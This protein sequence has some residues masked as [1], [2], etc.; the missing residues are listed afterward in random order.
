MPIVNMLD[1]KTD[2]SKLAAAVESDAGREVIIAR[3]DNQQRMPIGFFVAQAIAEPY[4]FE[5][6]ADRPLRPSAHPLGI[7]HVRFFALPSKGLTVPR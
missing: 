1:A 4:I 3:N 7:G 2:L 5:E 6:S